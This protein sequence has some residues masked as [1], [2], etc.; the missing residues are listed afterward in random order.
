MKLKYI[1]W[2][3]AVIIMVFIFMFS[4]Q[5]ASVSDE[6]SQSF[7]SRMYDF[8]EG[9]SNHAPTEHEK[10]EILLKINF[11]VRK[12]AH[13]IEYGILCFFIAFHF[14]ALRFHKYKILLYSVV[15]S[16]LYA[17]TDEFH[18]LFVP[19]R[20]GQI[21]DVV[22]DTIGAILGSIIFLLVLPKFKVW[23]KQYL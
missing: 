21:G 12:V 10:E 14:F 5:E 1:S 9:V 8:Y 17:M 2:I 15:V 19:G 6:T 11:I 23:F 22:I 18:Q 7:A 20:S 13:G 3:P 16:M 4:S